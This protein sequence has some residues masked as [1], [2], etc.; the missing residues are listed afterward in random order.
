MGKLIASYYLQTRVTPIKTLCVPRLELCAALLGAELVGTILAALDDKRFTTPTVHAW[1][2]SQVALAWVNDHPK[3]WKTFVANRVAKI[4]QIIPPEKWSF[5]TTTENPAD[6]ASRG[7]TAEALNQHRLWWHGPAWLKEKPTEWPKPVLP[8]IE[9]NDVIAN[10]VSS[11]PANSQSLQPSHPI[12]E[13]I[14]RHS[15][16]QKIFRIFAWCRRFISSLTKTQNY[17]TSA[18]SS[19]MVRLDHQEVNKARIEAYSVMQQNFLH[20]FETLQKGQPLPATSELQKLSPFYDEENNVIRVGGRLANTSYHIDKRFPILLPKES[21]LTTLVI[22]DTHER[23]LHCGSQQTLYQIRQTH[24]IPGGIT[25]VKRVLRQCT[26]CIR[27]NS[28]PMHPSMG[29]LPTERVTVSHPFK[30]TGLDYAGPIIVKNGQKEERAY[31]AIFICFSS[32]AV[33]IETVSSLTK[34]DCLNAI[35]RFV[36]RR[37]MP[38]IIFSD[39]ARTFTGTHGEIEVRRL[40][41]SQEFLDKLQPFL[42]ENQIQ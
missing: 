2:G 19:S 22:R 23:N 36:A 26:K 20:Y 27:F 42:R 12:F 10:F 11:Q 14:E 5:V 24:W 31:I 8:E 1:T 16:L 4:Q 29:D 34:E 41:A 13:I 35:K 30:N 6:C 3:R 25:A 39:N 37:G 38:A 21:P 40:L 28:K 15:S 9:Q 17:S 7:I 18:N 32:K 33:H